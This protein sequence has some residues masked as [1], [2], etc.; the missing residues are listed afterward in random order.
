[1]KSDKVNSISQCDTDT[2][3]AKAA[4]ATFILHTQTEMQRIINRKGLRYRDLSRRMGVTEARVSQMFGDT[5]TNLT[6]KTVARVFH[7]LGETAYLTTLEE[8][9]RQL[10]EA[11][12]TQPDG[13]AHRWT[14]I[15][16]ESDK[17][18][19]AGDVSLAD[20][21]TPI[22]V[23]ASRQSFDRWVR[24]EA[25]LPQRTAAAAA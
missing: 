9:E 25:A 16:L 13:D 6:I 21:P 14:V 2:Y 12:G 17:F 8:V 1:M 3:A 7:H 20:A 22:D 23:P 5:A 15:G 11:R 10:A 24:A 18:Q 4:E 19:M